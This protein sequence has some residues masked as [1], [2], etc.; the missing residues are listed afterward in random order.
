MRLSVLQSLFLLLHIDWLLQTQGF[1]R[2]HQ[3]VRSR[4]V[5]SAHR[6]RTSEDEFSRAVNLACVLYFK[7][8][9]CLQRSVA[10]TLLLRRY[11]VDAQMVIGAQL[12]PFA[13]HAWV[14]VAG[15]VI[16]DKPYIKSLFQELERC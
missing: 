16:N 13:S 15:Q 7:P 1:A 3:L 10:L 6:V 2:V 8:V 5:E 11:G 14:E 4:A 12:F 9:L